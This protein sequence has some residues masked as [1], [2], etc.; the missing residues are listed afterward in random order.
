M[1]KLQIL[2]LILLCAIVTGCVKY[3]INLTNGTNFTVLGKPKFDKENGLYRYKSGGSNQT[4]SAQSV[5]SIE[6]SSD[7]DWDGPGSSDSGWYNKK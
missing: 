1:K 4:L 6:P 3:R 2:G 5:I 7:S